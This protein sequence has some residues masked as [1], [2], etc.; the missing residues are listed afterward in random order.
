[1]VAAGIDGVAVSTSPEL[2]LRGARGPLE[3]GIVTGVVLVSESTPLGPNV[4]PPVVLYEVGSGAIGIET[5]TETGT[6]TGRETGKEAGRETGREDGR[7]DGNTI[8]AGSPELVPAEPGVTLAAGADD[9]VV[10]SGTVE[11]PIIGGLVVIG[12]L[13]SPT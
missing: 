1:V 6:E 2:E 11:E 13:V 7:I 3:L 12:A 5:G 4:I 9:G 8:L 10:E